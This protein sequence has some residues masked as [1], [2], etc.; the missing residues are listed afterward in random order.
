MQKLESCSLSIRHRSEMYLKKIQGVMS[1]S[2]GDLGGR[3]MMS[4]SG[5]LKPSAVA[6]GPSVTRLTHSSCTA[7]HAKRLKQEQSLL[8]LPQWCSCSHAA[9][10]SSSRMQ[11]AVCISWL[12]D[13]SLVV[14]TQRFTGQSHCAGQNS[15]QC[16]CQ[17]ADSSTR[18]GDCRA[19]CLSS[20]VVHAQHTGRTTLHLPGFDT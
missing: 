11:S 12:G 20:R 13:H 4:T 10:S 2:L 19:W 6:G 14:L 9:G 15:A 5:G 17:E 18:R 7:V 16:P 1:C 3:S 8:C